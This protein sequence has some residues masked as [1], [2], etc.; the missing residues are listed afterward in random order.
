MRS[1]NV[2]VVL[3]T[4]AYTVP[5]RIVVLMRKNETSF[6]HFRNSNTYKLFE[7]P[8]FENQK[9]TGGYWFLIFKV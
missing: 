2:V 4:I 6:P 7:P 3:A 5:A 9:T 8:I 1:I